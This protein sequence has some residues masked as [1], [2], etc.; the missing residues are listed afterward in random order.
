VVNSMLGKNSTTTT[1]N[2]RAKDALSRKLDTETT[3]DIFEEHVVPFDNGL[4]P[5]QPEVRQAHRGEIEASSSLIE[6]K[7]SSTVEGHREHWQELHVTCYQSKPYVV[8]RRNEISML[9]CLQWDARCHEAERTSPNK[10]LLFQESD[11]GSL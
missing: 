7:R 4:L 1:E 8:K 3:F 2:P 10:R 9:L 6:M 11:I 5:N